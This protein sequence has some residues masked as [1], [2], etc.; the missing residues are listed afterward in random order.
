M[1]KIDVS[2]EVY[3]KINSVKTRFEEELGSPL[4][5]SDVIARSFQITDEIEGIDEV[6]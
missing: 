4:T 6:W 3:D 2:K 5:V 1:V